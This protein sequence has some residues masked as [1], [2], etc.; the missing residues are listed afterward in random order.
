MGQ[1][2]DIGKRG[3]FTQGKQNPPIRRQNR[4]KRTNARLDKNKQ[5][6]RQIASE[7]TDQSKRQE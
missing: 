7:A 3:L 1:G 6:D 5:A 4:H 2:A